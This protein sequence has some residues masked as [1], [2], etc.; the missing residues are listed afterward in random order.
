MSRLFIA[1][2]VLALLVGLAT[3]S[4]EAAEQTLKFRLVAYAMEISTIPATESEGHVL[5]IGEMRGA[6]IFEDGRLADKT[7]TLA[8]E[9]TKGTGKF[10]GYSTYTFEDGS[11]ISARFD[12]TS[13][14]DA[15]GRVIEGE[16]S[17]LTGTG[18]YEGVKGSGSFKSRAV[19]WKKGATLYDGEFKL[20][21]P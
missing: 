7:Y 20:M 21:L 17:E 18:Q 8:F 13:E 9:Y 16:Y 1:G 3:Y 6:A 2:P 15:K 12:G 14:A 11:S 10:H 19:A 4:A 5:G